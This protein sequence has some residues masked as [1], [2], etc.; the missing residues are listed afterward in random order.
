MMWIR[1]DLL[2][3]TSQGLR[4]L[5]HSSSS[6][7]RGRSSGRR[8]TLTLLGIAAVRGRREKLLAVILIILRLL[9]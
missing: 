5:P 9:V 4:L 1:S 2:P 3:T 7:L 6:G 8:Q